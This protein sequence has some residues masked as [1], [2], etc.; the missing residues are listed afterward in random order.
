MRIKLQHHQ[1]TIIRQ[2]FF[3]RPRR[4]REIII[5]IIKKKLTHAN[6]REVTLISNAEKNEGRF[7]PRTRLQLGVTRRPTW[8]LGGQWQWLLL[9]K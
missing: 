8:A 3:F 9:P 4:R 7:L 6:E 5:K 1:D 2:S